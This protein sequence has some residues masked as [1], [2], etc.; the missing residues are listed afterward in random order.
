MKKL[1][2]LPLFAFAVAGALVLG[3][4]AH[5]AD[6]ST[7]SASPAAADTSAA[8]PGGG[9]HHGERLQKL[10]EELGLTD[11]QKE[12]L[13]PILKSEFE[14]MK[15]VKEDTTLDKPAKKEKFKSIHQASMEQIKAIL[16][17]EQMEKWKEMRKE[18]HEGKKGD[19]PPMT[20]GTAAPVTTGTTP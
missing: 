1:N 6:T 2:A 8:G 10:A 15:A 7:A 3:P 11:A 19:A 18:H 20:T 14:Q 12:Q 13:K 17:P 5:G 16:T 4:V 9:H